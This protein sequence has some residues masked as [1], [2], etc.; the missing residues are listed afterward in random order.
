[1][2]SNLK[3]LVEGKTDH[4]RIDFRIHK[5]DGALVWFD[6][7]GYALRDHTGKLTGIE[8]ILSDIT[9]RK[10]AEGEL[11]FSHILLTT[12]IESS[13]DAILIVDANGRI[14]KFNQHFMSL[15]DV[16]RALVLAGADEPVLA[17]V[18]SRTKNEQEFLTRVRYL[19]DHPEIQSHEEV[20]LKD[21]RIIDRHSGSLYDAQRKYLGRVWFFRVKTSSRAAV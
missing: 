4:V 19:Y 11:I 6:S 3:L 13:P 7:E 8:G 16:P 20:E 14:I 10:L 9:E 1:M 2:M 15:W 21:G 17:A 5:P 18:T 12:A